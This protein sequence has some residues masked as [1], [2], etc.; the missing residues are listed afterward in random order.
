[1][2]SSIKIFNFPVLCRGN[3]LHSF[4]KGLDMAHN[5]AAPLV[6]TENCMYVF[7]IRTEHFASGLTRSAARSFIEGAGLRAGGGCEL[8]PL[9]G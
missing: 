8:P 2:F 5:G 1:V 7:D 6:D 4:F 9:A 3:H